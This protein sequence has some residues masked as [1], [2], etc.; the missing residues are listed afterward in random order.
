MAIINRAEIA[1]RKIELQKL[2]QK[3]IAD[4]QEGVNFGAG[5]IK[6]AES[7]AVDVADSLEEKAK[8]V[9]GKK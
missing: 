5:V 7:V 9:F 6:K 4:V 3:A 8:E 2:R 1:K